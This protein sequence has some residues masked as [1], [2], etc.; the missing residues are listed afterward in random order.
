[1]KRKLSKWTEYYGYDDDDRHQVVQIYY[2]QFVIFL[3]T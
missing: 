2:Y 1:M 3:T